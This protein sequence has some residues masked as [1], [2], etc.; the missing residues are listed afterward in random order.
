MA[1]EEDTRLIESSLERLVAV[2][3]SSSYS[4]LPR[5]I[6]IVTDMGILLCQYALGKKPYRRKILRT[7][8]RILNE[9]VNA[10]VEKAEKLMSSYAQI[11]LGFAAAGRTEAA[12]LAARLIEEGRET[13]ESTSPDRKALYSYW[14]GSI[15]KK[16][17][18]AGPAFEAFTRASGL[19]AESGDE[20]LYGNCQFHM[21]EIRL[22]QGK[23]DEARA[24]FKSCRAANPDHGKAGEY[25]REISEGV[26]DA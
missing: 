15:A 22:T 21:G 13:L 11:G 19:A 17:G 4:Q 10:S 6:Q 5:L 1:A 26:G 12:L 2:K 24:F 25:L 9:T 14:I 18:R 16:A 20:V 7:S 8:G 23:R 3:I